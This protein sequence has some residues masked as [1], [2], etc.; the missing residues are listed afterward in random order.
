MKTFLEFIKSTFI[1][2]VF[3]IL[4]FGLL[5]IVAMKIVGMLKPMATLIAEELPKGLHFPS[6]IVSVLLILVCLL[7]G[8]LARTRAG[9][10]AG[11]YFEDALLNRIP[12]Y[13]M[14]RSFTRRIGDV[15]ESEKFAPALVEIEEALVPG[16]VVEEHPQGLY[17]VFVPSAPTPAV[18]AIYIIAKERV[19]L[20]DASFLKTVKCIS[21]WGAGSGELLKA[22]RAPEA[23]GNNE[24][25][26][27]IIP[28]K[29]VAGAL[30]PVP[31][32]PGFNQKESG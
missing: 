24:G 2:G 25:E 29:T 6:V 17:T 27:H 28:L 3:V 26:P 11:S 14:L 13:S 12:G 7:A 21:R 23:N 5:A 31:G 18:G 20:V 22:M 19:H 15:E 16:F 32:T 1:G 10:G 30:A 9:Q 4:P 8:L